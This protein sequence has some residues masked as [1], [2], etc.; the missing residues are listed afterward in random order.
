MNFACKQTSSS[1][2]V[3]AHIRCCKHFL[4][5]TQYRC[6]SFFYHCLLCRM[7]TDRLTSTYCM[8]GHIVSVSH[9]QRVTLSACHIV[10]VSLCQRVIESAYQGVTVSA[11]HHGS[12][13]VTVSLFQ[14]VT[15]SACHVVS[16]SRC[17]RVTLSAC[18]RVS[19]SARQ[20]VAG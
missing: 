20:R 19:V 6:A 7:P 3:D 15:L 17:Q 13:S 10:S 11:C 4:T 18:R 9:R 8:S 14:R 16:V 12:V 2:F 1:L 5:F